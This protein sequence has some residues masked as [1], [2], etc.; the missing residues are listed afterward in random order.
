MKGGIET[1]VSPSELLENPNDS[2]SVAASILFAS[3]TLCV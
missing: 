3:Y 2:K 1:A